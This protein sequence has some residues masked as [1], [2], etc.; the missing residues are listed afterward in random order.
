VLDKLGDAELLRLRRIQVALD[1]LDAGTYGSCVVCGEP[2]A[3]A[4]LDAIPESDHC[5]HCH[6]S[7]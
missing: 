6:N 7:H 5:E 3:A 2:I 1:R 4:R